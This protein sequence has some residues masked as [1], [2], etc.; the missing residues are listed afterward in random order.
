[1]SLDPVILSR[2]QFAFVIAFHFL[3]PAFTPWRR[4]RLLLPGI[5]SWATATRRRSFDEPW[6][7]ED[8]GEEPAIGARRR[9]KQ[10]THRAVDPNV[11]K[12]PLVRRTHAAFRA[13]SIETH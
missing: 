4:T 12:N 8:R 7:V 1:M 11:A 10:E 13:A 9:A 3:L 5:P 2:L 6:K